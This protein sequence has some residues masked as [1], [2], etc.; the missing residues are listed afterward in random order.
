MGDDSDRRKFLKLTSCALGGGVGL[1]V[2]TPVLRLIADPAGKVTVTA[3]TTVDIGRIDRFVVGA[4]PQR[5]EVVAPIVKDA[6]TASRDIVLGAAW[7]RRPSTERIE[8]LSSVCPHLGCAVGFD[9]GKQRF[10]CPCHER[11]FAVD[12]G[13]LKTGPD[14][15]GLDAL[16]IVVKDG[17]LQLTWV[18]YKSGGSAKVPV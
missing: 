16:P 5:V 11:E 9:P 3:G 8:A 18:R 7:I 15:R 4:L 17:R 12:G 10:L 14:E 6:W 1:A 13:N 2:V